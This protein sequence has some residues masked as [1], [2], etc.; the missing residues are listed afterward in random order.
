MFRISVIVTN[1]LGCPLH[2][3]FFAVGAKYPERCFMAANLVSISAHGPPPDEPLIIT[4]NLLPNSYPKSSLNPA[5]F[6]RALKTQ[7][8]SLIIWVRSVPITS[9]R[10]YRLIASRINFRTAWRPRRL[11]TNDSS[12][13]RSWST[14]RHR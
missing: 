2:L 4:S 1:Q 12:T 9:G 3:G 11:V 13:S 14:A 8:P 6:I 10:P 7:Y 5:G